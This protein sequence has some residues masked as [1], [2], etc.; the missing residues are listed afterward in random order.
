MNIAELPKIC[1]D[2]GRPRRFEHGMWLCSNYCL[3]LSDAQKAENKVPV[4]GQ[5]HIRPCQSCGEAIEG[6][7]SLPWY[8]CSCAV[9]ARVSR[10]TKLL[11]ESLVML[12]RLRMGSR[13]YELADHIEQ[14]LKP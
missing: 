14:E 2:C 7:Y 8:C 11:E 6:E 12:R 1:E 10:R 3:E 9:N 4:E 5:W 13:A